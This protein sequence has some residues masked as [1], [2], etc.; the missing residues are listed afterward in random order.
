MKT[1]LIKKPGAFEIVEIEKPRPAAG[2]II[3]Q[4]KAVCLCNQHDWKVNKGL[5]R[6]LI[7][8]EYGVPGFPGHEG[9]GIVVET[10]EDVTRF[11][12]GD[13]VAL[14]GLGG[15]PLYAEYVTRDA[16]QV[17]PVDK[18]I[19]FEQ[20]A[21]SELLG[22][23]HRAC[24]KIKMYR[25]RSVVVSGCGPGG[26][27]AIQIVKALGA[28]QVT[29]ID[30]NPVRLELALE[31]GADVAVNA[32]RESDVAQLKQAGADVVIECSGNKSAYQN[33]FY[34]ARESIIIFA[35]S[36]GML[37]VPLWQL[38]DLELTI[39]NSKWLTN[40]D[41]RSVVR[42]IESGKIRTAQMISLVTR[43]DQYPE[44]V[45]RIGRGEIIKAVMIP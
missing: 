31:L 30:I 41:L 38:F 45:E 10:G 32:S 27:A 42:M 7:Y 39:Y 40:D 3:V 24:R 20:V 15:P 26:L 16:N 5:Y 43:F 1:I 34:I 25:G 36:E 33:A 14:S 22:C 2:E 8:L 12:A 17:A 37:E 29:A 4:L 35:Y 6:D 21:M 9:A 23:V 19:P 28:D 44:V 11:Q 18:S 13:H